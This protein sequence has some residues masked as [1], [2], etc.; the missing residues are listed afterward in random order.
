M[1]YGV[2]KLVHRENGRWYAKDINRGGSQVYAF[3]FQGK[4]AKGKN[5]RLLACRKAQELNQLEGRSALAA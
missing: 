3:V 1:K 5:A 2:Y 4:D